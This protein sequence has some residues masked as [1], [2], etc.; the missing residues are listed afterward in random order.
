MSLQAAPIRQP[1]GPS[2]NPSADSFN[3]IPSAPISPPPADQ[4]SA[5]RRNNTIGSTRHQPSA[6][7]GGS[8]AASGAFHGTRYRPA[9]DRESRFRSGSL[10]S[11]DGEG[12]PTGLSRKQSGREVRKEEV[13]PEDAEMGTAEMG[14]WGNSSV[15]GGLN[16]QSS[17][18]SRR[19]ES[20]TSSYTFHI[21]ADLAGTRTTVHPPLPEPMAPPPRPPRRISVAGSEATS[22]P[23]THSVSQSLSSLAMLNRPG[24]SIDLSQQAGAAVSRAQSLRSQARHGNPQLETDPSTANHLGRSSS[25]RQAGEV[26]CVERIQVGQANDT[27]SSFT[28]R[29]H[30]VSKSCWLG[31]I[32]RQ[33]LRPTHS[34]SSLVCCCATTIPI[35]KPRNS[36]F[37]QRRRH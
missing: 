19:G 31:W 8:A 1:R 13:V 9:R 3:P 6:S 29:H 11:K 24:Q 16:R 10:S 37:A 34:A 25:L 4:D 17:L 18:P 32:V 26:S 5:L 27:A 7:I 36:C 23:M 15:A 20:I 2:S 30:F 21:I 28:I 35:T 12:V 33:S 22:P 14:G